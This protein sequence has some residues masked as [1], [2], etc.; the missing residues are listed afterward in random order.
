[1]VGFPK[2][3]LRQIRRVGF[4]FWMATILFSSCES[5]NDEIKRVTAG[6]NDPIEEITQFETFYSDSGIVK[7]RVTAPKLVK[8]LKPQTIT[9]LP[10][11]MLIQFFDDKK[12]VISRLSAKYAIHYDAEHRW[13]AQNDVVVV[14]EKGEQLN[15]EKLIWDEQKEQLYSD[16]FVKI[17]TP[18]EIIMGKGFEANQ[19]FS[20]YKIFNVTGRITVKE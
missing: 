9:K 12:N 7:V 13:E 3:F 10:N 1:M 11:G 4:I 19:D 8:L 20:R 16:Q 14:N 17:T 6:P 18:E 15:T 2:L 5:D